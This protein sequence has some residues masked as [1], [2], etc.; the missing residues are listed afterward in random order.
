MTQRIGLLGGTFD[1]IHHGH[2][3]AALE[4]RDA[5][6]LDQVRLIPS[7]RPPHRAVPGANAEQRLAMV[8]LAIADVAGLFADA[9]ELERDAPSYTVDT[10]LSLRAELGGEVQLILLLG[11]DA[12][13][14]LPTWHRWQSLLELAH[15]LVLQRPDQSVELPEALKDLLAARTVSS[16]AALA[17]PAGQISFMQQTPLAISATHIR[18]LCQAGQSID[19]LLP[20]SVQHYIAAHGLY[21]AAAHS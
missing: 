9:R 14:G 2:L 21:R 15:L 20:S 16:P 6:G 8:Q 3:R 1:P 13:C 17:G 5:L 11:W 4:V 7:A 10:L 19:F 12:F 18:A